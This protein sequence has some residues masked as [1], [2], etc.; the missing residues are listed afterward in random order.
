MRKTSC[1]R[2]KVGSITKVK[3]VRWLGV[4]IACAA[5]GIVICGYGH[6]AFNRA[7]QISGEA[8]VKLTAPSFGI[9]YMQ[10][11]TS[12]ICQKAQ[13]GTESVLIDR[14]DNKKYFVEKMQ[15]KQ[16]WMTQ[17]LAFDIPASGLTGELSDINY[18][19]NAGYQSEA[20]ADGT[21]VYKWTSSSKVPVV[22]TT[23]LRNGETIPKTETANAKSAYSW[24]FGE[25]V[26]KNPLGRTACTDY[27]NI[28]SCSAYFV[29]VS[30]YM[31]DLSYIETGS[32]YDAEAK[33][34][35]PHFL[36]GNYY[37]FNTA[38]AG[39][40]QTKT[41]GNYN[42]SSICPK[43]WEIPFEEGARSTKNLVEAYGFTNK[44]VVSIDGKDY[45]AAT[46]PIYVVRAGYIHP[47]TTRKLKSAGSRGFIWT[48][49]AASSGNASVLRV[50][51]DGVL[52]SARSDYRY[53]GRAV[54][55][56]A[57]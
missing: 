48:N 15:D 41:S 34:Y 20:L 3:T 19:A 40:G 17:N 5:L 38:I 44:D 8:Q 39:T 54:R 33:V 50:D 36:V 55:C 14:R 21:E 18:V 24:N 32:T 16:C 31:P 30:D 26:V 51:G 27:G 11:M 2:P 28:S 37:Q 42:G 12:E 43:G 10:D 23:I 7:L 22:A 6:A 56:V 9:E 25:W 1:R 57:R 49:Y 47:G 46:N 53:Y 29:N 13:V 35:D 4:V 45:Y 52:N